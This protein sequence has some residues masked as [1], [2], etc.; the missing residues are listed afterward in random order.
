MTRFAAEIGRA[1]AGTSVIAAGR[2]QTVK[3]ANRIVEEGSADPIGLA[4]VLFADPLWVKK[5][6]GAIR[7]P[8]IPCEAI[9]SLCTKR[10]M[11]GKPAFCPAASLSLSL[12]LPD[13]AFCR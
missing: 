11:S 8:I 13:V 2:I 3:T 10:V 7:D 4:R 9:C 12:P 6:S 5:A 1:V